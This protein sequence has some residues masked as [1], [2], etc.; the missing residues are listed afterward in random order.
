MSNEQDL[1]SEIVT[2]QQARLKSKVGVNIVIIGCC[3]LLLVV[4][5]CC[6]LLLVVVGCCWLLLVVVVGG[7]GGADMRMNG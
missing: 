7:G 2:Q 1:E 4:V 3:W 5:G 6:W